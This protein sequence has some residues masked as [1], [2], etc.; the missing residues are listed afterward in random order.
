MKEIGYF[1]TKIKYKIRKN[2]K[3]VICQYFRKSGMR[4]GSGCNIC[5]NIMTSEPYLVEI[6]DNVTI[7]GN[8]MFVTHDNSISK[9]IEGKTDIFG[10]ITIGNNCFI[11]SNATILYGVSLCDNVIVAA[12]SVVTNSFNES[13]IIIGGN[14]AKK[15]GDWDKFAQKSISNAINVKNMTYKE[16]KDLVLRS[17][18]KR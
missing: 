4:I 1:L 14:P 7:A 5:C 2:N 11:G 16:K 8:V 13:A 10:K 15:I 9:V 18:I 3:E 6:G 17:Y 12:G